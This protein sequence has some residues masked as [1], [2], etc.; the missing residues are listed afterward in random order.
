MRSRA[1]VQP[2]Y[3]GWGSGVPV[4]VLGDVGAMVNKRAPRKEHAKDIQVVVVMTV[5]QHR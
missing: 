5:E 3:E 1:D 2:G 4:L